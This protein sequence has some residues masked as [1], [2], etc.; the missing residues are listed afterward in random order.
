MK[1][2]NNLQNVSWNSAI[3]R[4]RSRLVAATVSGRLFRKTK[5]QYKQD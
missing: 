5:A 4:R 3:L 1:T 2:E